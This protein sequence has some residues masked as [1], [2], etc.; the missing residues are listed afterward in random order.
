MASSSS[1]WAAWSIL[2]SS[3]ITR[4]GERDVRLVE[5]LRGV[6]DAHGDEAGDLDE[7]IL[8][9]AQFL[10]EYF[11]HVCVPSRLAWH[12]LACTAPGMLGGA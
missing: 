1:S 9:L 4:L 11:A 6:L 8:H 3:A 12:R 7:A 10:L 5:G 2:L